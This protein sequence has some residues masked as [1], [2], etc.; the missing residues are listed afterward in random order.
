MRSPFRILATVALG[1][2]FALPAPAFAAVA[3]HAPAT[4]AD[5]AVFV[6][7]DDPAGNHVVAYHRGANG[8][9]TLAGTYSTGG[10]G[11]VL[12]GSVVDHLASQGSLTYDR[13]HG[14]LFA[15]NAGSDS[16]SVFSA[17]G[18]HLTRRQV[19]ASGG[20]FPVSVAVHDDLVYVLNARDGG[21]VQ[22]YGLRNGRLIPLRHARADLGL[23]STASPEFVNTPG[24]VAFSPSGQQL[25][26]TTKANGNDVDVFRVGYFGELSAP[27]VNA[28]PGAVPFAIAFDHS[29]HLVLAEAG[30]NAV[31]SFELNHD[32]TIHALDS[33]ATGQAATCWIAG[34][35]GYL[36]AS[37]AGSGSISRVQPAANGA[38]TLLGATT[39]DAGTVDAAASAAGRYLYVQTGASGIVDGFHVGSDGSLTS[40]GSVTVASAVGGEGIV[41]V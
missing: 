21:V 28:L 38:L 12:D 36:F 7:T 3:A 26:V 35:Q 14:L 33:V 31:A 29:R 30:T 17:S 22:G 8:A 16:V 40:V 37:N 41:A 18:D 10:R 24:Q 19:I 11:G 1:A 9:L 20:Q 25:V 2:A 13:D 4:G 32:G 15:V 27:T 23:D 5:H 34:A 6:Q 39:T